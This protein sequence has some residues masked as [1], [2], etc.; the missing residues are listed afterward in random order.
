MCSVEFAGGVAAAMR[1]SGRAAGR[2]AQGQAIQYM[3]CA[4]DAVSSNAVTAAKRMIGE[5]L[6]R[7]WALGQ[8]LGSAK[9]AL[10][11]GTGIGEDDFAIAA[12]RIRAGDDPADVLDD[13]FVQSFSLAGRPEEC[14]TLAR[15]YKAMGIDELALTFGGPKAQDEI[16]QMGAALASAVR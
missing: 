6:P 14:L 11:A 9:E 4:T 10:L 5:M 1:A 2:E 8:K 15:K 7:F 13:R 3:P 12:S 16:R